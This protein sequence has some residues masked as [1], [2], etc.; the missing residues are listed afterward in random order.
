MKQAEK[1]TP[2][3]VKFVGANYPRQCG[4]LEV[5]GSFADKATAERVSDSIGGIA[6]EYERRRRAAQD[7]LSAR[8]TAA[9]TAANQQIARLIAEAS[10]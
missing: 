9:I 5:V 2:R 10:K 7:E 6:G 1:V 3:L 4:I 8:M